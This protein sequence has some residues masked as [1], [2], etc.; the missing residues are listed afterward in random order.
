[1]FWVELLRGKTW[2]QH[3]VSAIKIVHGVVYLSVYNRKINWLK[4]YWIFFFL[5]SLRVKL[6]LSSCIPAQN[7]NVCS[8]FEWFVIQFLTTGYRLVSSM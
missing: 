7:I 4:K 2:T 3:L 8:A 5:I 6:C 1:M